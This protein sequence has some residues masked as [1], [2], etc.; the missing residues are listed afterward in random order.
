MPH[1]RNPVGCAVVLAAATR[2]PAL[3]SIMLSSMVQEHERGLGGWHAEWETLPEICTLTAGAIEHTLHVVS[4]LEIDVA[5]M[6]ANLE[7]TRGLIFAEA[8]SMALAVKIG[9]QPAHELVEDACRNSIEQER[10]LL[11]LLADDVRVS[12]HL[13]R[14]DLAKLFDPAAYLGSA[15][16]LVDR[17]REAER[18]G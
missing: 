9:R 13:S 14:A 18:P 7:A 2:V 11:D 10:P 17:A 8:V 3:V 6:R 4:G 1:K 12:T 5:R 15:G 16:I